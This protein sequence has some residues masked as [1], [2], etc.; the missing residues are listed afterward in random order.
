MKLYHL[1]IY[2]AK[3]T[4]IGEINFYAKSDKK[5]ILT[6]HE[7]MDRQPKHLEAS[8]IKNVRSRTPSIIASMIRP[9]QRNARV[10]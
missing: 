9:G 5:A 8:L 10:F 1:A 3:G 2:N 7:I 6:S 4:N